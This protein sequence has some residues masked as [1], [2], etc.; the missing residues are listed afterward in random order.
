M[1]ILWLVV[2]SINGISVANEALELCKR[3]LLPAI[4][5]ILQQFK[6]AGYR[7]EALKS[8]S[9]YQIRCTL[10]NAVFLAEPSVFNTLPSLARS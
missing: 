7:E 5:R 4:R 3:L 1:I 10:S 9:T 8:Q 2:S 6:H